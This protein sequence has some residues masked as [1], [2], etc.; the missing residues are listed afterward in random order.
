MDGRDCMCSLPLRIFCSAGLA[1]MN[2]LSLGLYRN[3]LI[4]SVNF[5]FAGHSSKN[6]LYHV[7]LPC[8]LMLLVTGVMPSGVKGER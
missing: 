1:V 3:I 5:N 8:L 7:V 4:F 6:E 2:Y